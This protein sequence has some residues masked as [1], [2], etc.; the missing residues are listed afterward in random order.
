MHTRH[1]ARAEEEF[2]MPAID[3]QLRLPPVVIKY[4]GPL[5]PPVTPSPP[6][7]PTAP[8]RPDGYDPASPAPDPAR[9]PGPW[10]VVIKYGGPLKPPRAVLPQ[11]GSP[12]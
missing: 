1:R 5:M 3:T 10:G 7:R 8:Q 9:R 6:P 12:S 4:G 11:S 2:N